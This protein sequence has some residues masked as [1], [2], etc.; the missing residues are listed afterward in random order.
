[1]IELQQALHRHF[2]ISKTTCNQL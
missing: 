1:V 2:V